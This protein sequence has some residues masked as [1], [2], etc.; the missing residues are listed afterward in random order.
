M[1]N[2]S[3]DSSPISGEEILAAGNRALAKL[4]SDPLHRDAVTKYDREHPNRYIPSS[5]PRTQVRQLVA[6]D[7]L[8]DLETAHNDVLGPSKDENQSDSLDQAI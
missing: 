1:Q 8:A 4:A 5:V 3:D 7:P 6:K 2:D